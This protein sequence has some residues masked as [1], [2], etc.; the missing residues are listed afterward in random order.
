ML[1]QLAQYLPEE[2]RNMEGLL[3]VATSAQVLPLAT[4]DCLWHLHLPVASPSACALLKAVS[5]SHL[6]SYSLFYLIHI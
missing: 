6:L 3:A 2:H 4:T 5:T 1:E